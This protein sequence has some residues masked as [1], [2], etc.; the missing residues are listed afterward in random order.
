MPIESQTLTIWS[1]NDPDL[2]MT[3]TSF[4]TLNLDKSTK[5]NFDPVTLILK[6]DLD[7]IKMYH[8]RYRV[9]EFL[10]QVQPLI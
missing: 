7:M 2:G 4:M 8:D 3:F 10:T 5:L 6:L 9:P 1:Y